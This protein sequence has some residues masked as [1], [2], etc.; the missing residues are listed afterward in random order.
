M[1]KVS[2]GG[3]YGYGRIGQ[4]GVGRRLC[5]GGRGCRK[6]DLCGGC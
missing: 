5:V 6:K 3:E 2:A 4:V 1:D